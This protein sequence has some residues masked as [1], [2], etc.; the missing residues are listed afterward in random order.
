MVKPH[1]IGH[2]QRLRDR[3]AKSGLAGFADYEVIELLLTLVIPR[4]D[5]KA[6]AKGLIERCGNLRGILDAP[7]SVLRQVKGLGIAAPDALRIIRAAAALYL[8]QS[9]EGAAAAMAMDKLGD[10]WRLAESG[11]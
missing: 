10:Y 4:P 2:R 8:Q 1:Y 7:A 6:P 3:F 5:G 9:A 11:F